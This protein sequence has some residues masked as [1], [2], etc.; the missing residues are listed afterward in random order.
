MSSDNDGRQATMDSTQIYREETFTDRKVGT[1]R[2]LT[3]VTADGAADAARPVLFVGQAQVM[4]PMGAVPDQLRTRGRDI[5]C[6]DRKIRRGRR[7]RRCSK[8]CA[9]CRRCAA[10]RHPRWSFPM[11]PARGCRIPAICSAAAAGAPLSTQPRAASSPARPSARTRSRVPRPATARRCNAAAP[12][13]SF[14]LETT[15]DRR[16]PSAAAA[17]SA[18]RR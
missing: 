9:N 3:P 13:S 12:R 16:S 17:C 14:A 4:T 15:P 18:S 10:S 6:G 1:I 7:S 5:E 8:P 2:R 11:P